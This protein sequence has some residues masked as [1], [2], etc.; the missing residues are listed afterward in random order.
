MKQD[1]HFSEWPGAYA[2][3]CAYGERVRRPAR[4]RAWVRLGDFAKKR[5]RSGSREFGDACATGCAT[6]EAMP[7]A[8]PHPGSEP[9]ASAVQATRCT[10]YGR[11]FSLQ[12][13]GAWEKLFARSPKAQSQ[14][15]ARSTG[16]THRC[17]AHETEQN[18]RRAQCR[19]RA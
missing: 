5:Y 12:P 14:P 16:Y 4:G 13:P 15:E 2:D 10:P 9:A 19:T 3:A 18:N 6:H 7:A 17:H 1:R 8:V 11:R